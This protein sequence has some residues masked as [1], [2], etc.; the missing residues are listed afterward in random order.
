MDKTVVVVT[1]A[2]RGIGRNTARYFAERGWNVIGTGRDEKQIERVRAELQQ[3]DANNDMLPVDVSDP[4]QVT[5]A[6]TAVIE[7]YG[8]IDLWINNAGAFMGIGLSWEVPAKD[9]LND[10]QT[11]LFGTMH[12]VQAILP[13]MLMR[14]GGRIINLVGG[15]TQDAFA[16]GNAYGVSKTAVARYTENLVVELADRPVKVFALDPGL[17]DTDMTRYQRESAVGRQYLADMLEPLFSRQHDVPP[18]RLPEWAYRIAQGE[19]D[20]Y[21]GRIISV[22]DDI[23]QLKSN[24]AQLTDANKLRL[25]LMR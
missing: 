22:Y 17:N 10:I 3:F 6:V 9:W 20:D 24:A 5:Q 25:R 13:H 7:R 4:Q 2:S 18:E 14:G 21:V 15:G 11:N 8:H 12:C 23:E 1:G 19:L 16:Y